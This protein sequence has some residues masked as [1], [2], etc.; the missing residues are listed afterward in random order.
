M[1]LQ[2]R[3]IGMYALAADHIRRRVYRHGQGRRKKHRNISCRRSQIR[4]AEAAA[5]AYKFHCDSP[6]PGLNLRTLYQ[7]VRLDAAPAG[8][9]LHPA[10][11]AA[12][13]NAAAHAFRPN[14]AAYIAQA[15]VAASGD[16][17]QVAITL[18]NLNAAAPGLNICAM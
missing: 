9:D 7:L 4:I 16:R 1:N 8:G 18:A 12:H 5:A 10:L 15:N 11:G 6:R 17:T 13:M 2:P 14:R 3:K